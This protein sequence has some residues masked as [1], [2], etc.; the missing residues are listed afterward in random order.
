M[1]EGIQD[2]STSISIVNDLIEILPDDD[3]GDES[4]KHIRA[5]DRRYSYLGNHSFSCG[6]A[7]RERMISLVVRNFIP[8]RAIGQESYIP[9]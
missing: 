6:F 3:D 8:T 9:T 4:N 2:V 5:R 1:D 7:A